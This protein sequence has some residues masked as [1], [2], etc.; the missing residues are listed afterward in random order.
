MSFSQ[1]P[2]CNPVAEWGID[3]TNFIYTNLV[4]LLFSAKNAL[5]SYW[6]SSR[7]IPLTEYWFYDLGTFKKYFVP[8]TDV[9]LFLSE[10]P[11]IQSLED[12]WSMYDPSWIPLARL[13]QLVLFD[14]FSI[15]FLIWKQ[16]QGRR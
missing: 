12:S 2:D 5:N 14:L 7:L 3:S 9:Y 1:G 13:K 4:L 15:C 6:V 16:L 11:F 8:I 10:L